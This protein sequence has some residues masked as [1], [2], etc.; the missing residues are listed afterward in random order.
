MHAHKQDK[1]IMS[2]PHS[3][4]ASAPGAALDVAGYYYYHHHN[5]IY[6][7]RER[8]AYT[9]YIYIYMYMYI[10]IYTYLTNFSMNSKFQ[11]QLGASKAR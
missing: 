10:Y 3:A 4:Q 7:C 11:I 8:G 6:I 9:I 1:G 5:Y 2:L